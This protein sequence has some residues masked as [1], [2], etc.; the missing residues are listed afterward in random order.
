MEFENLGKK[1]REKPVILN[2]NHEKPRISNW[3]LWVGV[4]LT[5]S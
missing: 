3:K 1:N 2:K 4:L 5:I